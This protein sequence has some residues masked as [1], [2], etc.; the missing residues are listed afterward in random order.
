VAPES[1]GFWEKYLGE[2]GFKV[3]TQERFGERLIAFNHPC[4]IEY[5]LVGVREDSRAPYSNGAVPTEHG[6]RGTHGI[7]VSVRDVSNSDEFMQTGWNGKKHAADGRYIRYEVGKGGS[8]TIVDFRVE[9]N[10]PQGSWV[11]GEGVPHHVAFE[12]D[13]HDVQTTVKFHLEGLG[14]T[15]LRMKDR[16]Y[17][18]S[19][20][21]DFRWGAL[22]GNRVSQKGSWSTKP[23]KSLV[24]RCRSAVLRQPT[25]RL[26][27]KSAAQP[28]R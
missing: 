1:L 9:P 5:E 7:A 27:D 22:R 16:G 21:T 4:G 25:P 20:C 11:Y 23:T 13:N 10:L 6:I 28:E 15:D 12:V 26:L 18:D 3:T 8:G 2:R 17:F 24:R 14:F 19:T